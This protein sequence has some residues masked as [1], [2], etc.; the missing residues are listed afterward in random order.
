MLLVKYKNMDKQRIIFRGFWV[1]L[2]VAFVTVA[3]FV[4]DYVLNNRVGE[5]WGWD[6]LTFV[7][8]IQSWGY[9]S[10]FGFRH[11]GLG[12]VLSP[13]VVLEHLWSGA[14]L[15]VLPG[16]ALMTAYLIYKMSNAI[17]LV[18]WLSFPVTW[19]M[20]AIPESF[21]IAQLTL[22]GS[23]YLMHKKDFSSETG[24]SRVTLLSVIALSIINS[25]VTLTNGVKP[26]LAYLITCN[27]R[28]TIIKLIGIALLLVIGGVFFFYVRSLV[29]GRSCVFGIVKTLSWIPEKRALLQ[30]LYGFFIKPV[31]V[32]QSF[33]VY[34]LL[35]YCVVLG[36]LKG[37]RK[38]EQWISAFVFVDV[39]LHLAIGWGM[40]EP[41][42]FA[43]HW[44]FIIPL[45][46][47]NGIL[48]KK[49][50]TV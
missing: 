39:A 32:I 30:E 14:Y 41:W 40:Q 34:P 27:N 25:M 29:C 18:V 4:R 21:P 1:G 13:L 46:V 36:R 3:F 24:C 8:Q 35:V 42:V 20:A 16:V 37:L 5:I 23:L 19:L 17:G 9:I 48:K 38:L 2:Y 26:M 49:E 50:E 28:R 11:P 43:P 10:Y 6:Y 33:I 15:L 47:G 7:K 12:L 22:V 44:I 31:G 45:I